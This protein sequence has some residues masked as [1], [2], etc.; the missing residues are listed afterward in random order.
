VDAGGANS[1]DGDVGRKRGDNGR[2]ARG[3]SGL[4]GLGA[5]G[6]RHSRHDTEGVCLLEVAGLGVGIRVGRG[7]SSHGGGES[8]DEDI[9]AHVD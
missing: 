4:V 3:G 7:L 9:G 6:R 1:R 5:G 8:R 2:L